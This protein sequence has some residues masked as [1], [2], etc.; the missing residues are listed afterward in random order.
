MSSCL[1]S[2]QRLGQ[3]GML[4][5]SCPNLWPVLGVCEAAL[6][7]VGI[8]RTS[9]ASWAPKRGARQ[10]PRPAAREPRSLAAESG[11]PSTRG[12]PRDCFCPWL[13]TLTSALPPRTSRS[14][15]ARRSSGRRR[16]R[17]RLGSPAP[18]GC[19]DRDQYFEVSGD[20]EALGQEVMSLRG[21][22]K[23]RLD[24]GCALDRE[25]AEAQGRQRKKREAEAAA[26]TRQ[27]PALG[28]NGT[29]PR[30]RLGPGSKR[31]GNDA[32]HQSW[33]GS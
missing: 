31:A 23:R 24:R 1:T 26:Q 13:P 17:A 15:E 4:L 3:L 6:G 32:C 18:G 28:N 27:N 21:G 12:S 2:R 9:W 16:S 10:S 22:L 25:K 19:T 5:P 29:L 30:L 14:R 20:P 8:Q 7:G 33:N 11:A